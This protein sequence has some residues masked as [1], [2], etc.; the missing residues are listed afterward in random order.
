MQAT[1]TIVFRDLKTG[2]EVGDEA[3]ARLST[4]KIFSS[5]SFIDCNLLDWDSLGET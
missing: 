4:K 5:P 3:S 2:E 1:E